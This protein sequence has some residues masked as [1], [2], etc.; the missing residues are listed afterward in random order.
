MTCGKV[1]ILLLQIL[2]EAAITQ[3]DYLRAEP[4]VRESLGCFLKER[5]SWEYVSLGDASVFQPFFPS[6][7]VVSSGGAHLL[8]PRRGEEIDAHSAVFRFNDAPADRRFADFVGSK[9]TIRVINHFQTGDM[10]QEDCWYLLSESFTPQGTFFEQQQRLG[11]LLRCQLND[12][13]NGAMAFLITQAVHELFEFPSWGQEGFRVSS[14]SA[15]MIMALN[16]CG[17]VDAYDMTSSELSRQ[18]LYHYYDNSSGFGDENWH[19][20]FHA[21]QTLWEHL[22]EPPTEAEKAKGKISILGFPSL[23]CQKQPALPPRLPL[24]AG[25][26]S[27]V[28]PRVR[29]KGGVSMF[30]ETLCVLGA[31]L[32]LAK[33]WRRGG[34]APHF[35]RILVV[36]VALNLA[37]QMLVKREHEER[38]KPADSPSEAADLTRALVITSLAEALKL[39]VSRAMADQ[40][41]CRE[42]LWMMTP[43]AIIYTLNNMLAM[44]CVSVRALNSAVLWA[45]TNIVFGACFWML[46]FRQWICQERCLGLAFVMA[47]C[48]FDG[49]GAGADWRISL[50]VLSALLSSLGAVVME[51]AV[52]SEALKDKSIHS[53]N[54]H[55]Y[56]QTV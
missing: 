9:T 46:A 54:E 45:D 40:R 48:A 23:D 13:K 29:R 10:S 51:R 53:L 26:A 8:R 49:L 1:S 11:R 31:V 2:A 5:L 55:L 28:V 56:V 34:Q 37:L 24:P 35:D 41:L 43:G 52:K 38:Q 22:A 47:G 39:L 33:A 30:I 32:C 25:L 50:S 6:C 12:E 20:I 36:Y 3:R 15:G 19:H 27:E 4:L 7:A 18:A 44:Y 21:E 16:L 14:G 17:V 42:A